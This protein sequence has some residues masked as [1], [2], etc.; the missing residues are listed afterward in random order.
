MSELNIKFR[1]KSIDTN[2]WVYGYYGVSEEFMD[3]GY[4]EC[5]YREGIQQLHHIIEKGL[6]AKVHIVYPDSIA[7]Y[8][9]YKDKNGVEVYSDSIMESTHVYRFWGNSN[10]R[11]FQEYNRN[12]I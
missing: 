8:S 9:G 3:N 10:R 1:G 4:T 12:I 11:I 6:E 2:K 5:Y 7:L